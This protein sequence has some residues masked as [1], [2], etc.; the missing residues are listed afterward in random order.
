MLCPTLHDLQTPDINDHASCP[1]GEKCRYTHDITKFIASKPPDISD[2]CY[3]FEKFGMCPFG[4][5]CRCGSSHLTSDFVNIVIKGIYDPDFT[6]TTC[7]ILSK[8]LQDDLRKRRVK[9]ERSN[10]YLDKLEGRKVSGGQ[11]DKGGAEVCPGGVVR[12]ETDGVT[13]GAITDG[14]KLR[15]CEK[16]QVM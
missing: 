16:R 9:F 1:F 15:P 6:G 8:E 14:I 11:D 7:N 10:V 12:V 5:A 13:S 4:V 2:R 3:V